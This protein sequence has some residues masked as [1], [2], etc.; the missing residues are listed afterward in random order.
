MQIIILGAGQVGSS[1]AAS[2]AREE[3][4]IIVVDQNREN[5]HQLQEKF[6]LRT[7][8]G[9]AAHPDILE[10]AGAEDADMILAV[11]NSDE[12]NIVACQVIHTLF[13]TP[14]K[15]ARIRA[16]EYINQEKLFG[17]DSMPVD[18]VIS[19]EQ[20]VTDYIHRLVRNPG[21][22]Q[23]L[24]FA[25]GKI[26]LVAVKA[27]YGGPMVGQELQELHKHIPNVDTR[28]AAIFRKNRPIKPD[29][30]TI[31][32]ADDEVHFIA[33]RE[34][35]KAI[36]N[37][38]RRSDKPYKRIFI[39]GGG[40]IGRR[41]ALAL[42]NNYRVKIIDHTKERTK[43][44]S[45]ELNNTIVLTGDITD[46][47][48]M[49]EEDIDQVDLFCAVTSDDEDNILSSLLAKRLGTR[50]VMTL[51]NRPAYVDLVESGEIDIAISPQQATISGLL[52]Y[53]RRGDV[54]VA[55]SLRRGAAEAIEAIAHGDKDSSKVVGR[56]I[57]EIDL[58]SGTT[59]G[60]LLRGEEV[61]IAHHDTMIESEDHLIL[62]LV[63]KRMI[64]KVEQLFQVGLSFF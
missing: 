56:T 8:Y 36:M 12:T 9:H 23:V 49:Y 19:P 34:N 51:I 11:T 25:G 43:L 47:D 14:K 6:D 37:E 55:H 32:E 15:I 16:Q 4:D 35:V 22:L 33:A 45:E 48:L 3:N 21:A 61:I 10:Q 26:S 60:A 29:A 24:D 52:A 54:V 57:E 7:V 62:F 44:L 53:V 2:L 41:L 5:L 59:I 46:V 38:M 58:P 40:N 27:Y 17:K 64:H 31:I 30:H 50:R 39:A 63:D 18:A 42:E 13:N 1:V 28:V 20:M